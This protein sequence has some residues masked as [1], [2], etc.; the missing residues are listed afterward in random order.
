MLGNPYGADPPLPTKINGGA[1]TAF[2]MNLKTSSLFIT[3]HS[4]VLRFVWGINTG[5]L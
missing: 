5:Q 1:D 2:C 4:F 3:L